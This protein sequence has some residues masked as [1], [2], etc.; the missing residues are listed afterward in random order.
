MTRPPG[1]SG[2]AGRGPKV[3]GTRGSSGG[4]MGDSLGPGDGLL[5]GCWSFLNGLF[6]VVVIV[7]V[8]VVIGLVL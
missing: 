3:H 1:R 7:A 4:D 5:G 6:W 8:C 2:G